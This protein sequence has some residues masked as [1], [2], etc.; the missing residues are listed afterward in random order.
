MVSEQII[1]RTGLDSSLVWG[2]GWPEANVLIALEKLEHRVLVYDPPNRWTLAHWMIAS[3]LIFKFTFLTNTEPLIWIY[4]LTNMSSWYFPMLQNI[5]VSKIDTPK[6][7]AL[8]KLENPKRKFQQYMPC[9]RSWGMHSKEESNAGALS[10]L[11]GQSCTETREKERQQPGPLLEWAFPAKTQWVPWPHVGCWCAS[12][13]LK[14]WA[15]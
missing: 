14:H 13:I 10:Q 5:G 3:M 11:A 15:F 8:M 4:F 1:E 6:A 2:R 12:S 7:P 9:P